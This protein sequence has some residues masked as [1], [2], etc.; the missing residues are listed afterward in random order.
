M[1]PEFRRAKKYL[2]TCD[3]HDKEQK[4]PVKSKN[5]HFERICTEGEGPLSKRSI[6]A[7]ALV[8]DIRKGL[9]D[10][11]LMDRHELSQGQLQKIFVQLIKAGHV[12]QEELD[13][14]RPQQTGAA[15]PAPPRPARSERQSRGPSPRQ[16][17]KPAE[18]QTSSPS[19]PLSREEAARVRRNGLIL[20]VAS[21]V[22]WT[23]G[24]V[25]STL[26]AGSAPDSFLQGEFIVGLF[27][28]SVIGWLVTAILGC[29]WRV[30]GLGRHPVWAVV[31]PLF[32]LNIIVMA[33]LPNRYEPEAGRRNLW[34][35]VAVLVMLLWIM[36]LSLF[37]KNRMGL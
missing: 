20:I 4:Y 17:H 12:P 10:A 8:E 36:M 15:S 25:L 35:V 9:S 28:L 23:I 21:Y 14:R 19:L 30:R 16:D 13:G 6:S 2:P 31:A 1:F 24:T 5:T 37:I 27:F 26:G 3:I 7:K 34:L 11:E 22:L 18:P 33:A 29:L 32:V